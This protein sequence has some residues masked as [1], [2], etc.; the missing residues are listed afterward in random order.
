M[1][2]EHRVYAKSITS[3]FDALFDYHVTFRAGKCDQFYVTVQNV[4]DPL[5]DNGIITVPCLVTVVEARDG[6][7]CSDSPFAL[8]D[9]L[10]ITDRG[11]GT[12]EVVR[13]NVNA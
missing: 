6:N 12:V 9:K 4:D 1:A 10:L 8:S 2:T 5:Y 3:H 11:T 7:L 13:G